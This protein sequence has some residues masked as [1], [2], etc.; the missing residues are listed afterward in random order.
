MAFLSTNT[1]VALVATQTNAGVITLPSTSQVPFRQIIFKD[2]FGNFPNRTLTLSTSG[3]EVFED[4]RTTLVLRDTFGFQSLYGVNGRWYTLGGTSLTSQTVSSLTVSTINAITAN[5]S[6][7][8][9]ISSLIVNSLQFGDGTGWVNLGPLQTVAI[10]S[11]TDTTNSLFANN[12]YFGTT[13][14][15]TALQFYGL[16]GAFNNTVLAEIS[17]GAGTQELL[18]FR[19]ST[20][21]DRVRVQTTGTFVVETGV[22]QRLWNSNTTQTLSNA[23][24]AFII[25]TSSNVGIQTATPG[26]TLDFAGTGRFQLLSTLGL[27]VSSMNGQAYWAPEVSSIRGLGSAGYIST[28]QLTSTTQALQEYVSSFIDPVELASSILPFISAT[29]FAT[30][31]ASTVTG[32]GTSGYVSSFQNVNLISSLALWVCT[33]NGLPPGTGTGGLA[34]LPSTVSTFAL[35][36]SSF[37]ASTIQAI[38][39]STQAIVTSSITANFM[40]ASTGVVSS[41]ST[42]VISFTGGFGYLTMPDIFPNTVYTSTVTASNLLVGWN[43]VQSPIQFFGFG[44]YSNT[45]IAEL[46]TGA[47]NQ[48]LLMFRGSN[49][50]DRIRMQT[51][52]SIVFEPGVSQ[53]LWPTVPSNVT[54]AMVI[55]TSS[56]VGI[57]TASPSFPLDVAGMAR[58]ISLS[59]LQLQMSSVLGGSLFVSTL[60]VA[61]PSSFIGGLL[62]TSFLTGN[63]RQIDL[64][65]NGVSR[66][67]VLSSGFVGIG[68]SSPAFL[69]DVAGTG[70][71]S[72]ILTSS[73]TSWL[74]ISTTQLGTSSVVANTT[75][76]IVA[77]SF[78]MGAS[79]FT[80]KWNDAQYYVLQTI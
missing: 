35:L 48:E 30:S 63:S 18:L 79:T 42:N 55:N 58:A 78:Q 5:V 62:S 3:G 4:G 16:T 49:A 80:G 75:R 8:A 73:L 36:T 11:I 40:A 14:N 24:P 41:F 17:T 67:T 59:T 28:T 57:Q 70:E 72:T 10:S 19:G 77:S 6:T 45:V 9:T 38:T 2:S 32:L 26:A 50:S 25:N 71:F 66:L 1:E 65:T 53:R 12:S 60:S 39:L 68:V 27:N 51:T 13:S 61:G 46:S 76:S 21:T 43:S 29:Y 31:L 56:N 52:G 20:T 22:S 33:I 15:A 7:T 37:V 54:P 23:T 47:T 44:T 34:T 64:F 69:L 74:T